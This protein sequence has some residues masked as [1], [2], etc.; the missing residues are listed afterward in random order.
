VWAIQERGH[1]RHYYVAL[2]P[3]DLNHGE[4]LFIHF[5]GQRIARLLPLV[6]FVHSLTDDRRWEPPPMQATFMFDDPNLHWTSYGFIDY[7][8]MVANAIAGNYHVAVATIPLD[9]WFVHPPASAI[10]KDNSTRLSLL[11]HGNDHLSKELARPQPAAAMQRLL[12]QAVGR[13]A[14]MEARTRL[15]VARVMAPP[16]GACSETAIS[17]MAR[18]GFE[19][20]CV[21]RGSLRY[22]NGD[23]AWTRT[24]GMRPCD[25]VAGLPVIP[26]FGLSKNCRNDILIAALLRQPIVPMTHHQAVADGYELLDEMASFVNSLGDVTWR[27]MKTMSRSLYSHRQDDQALSVRMLSKRISVPVSGGTTRIRVERPWL[28]QDSAEEPLLWRTTTE[29]RRW[30]V[31]SA[32]EAIA[33][34]GGVTIEIASGPARAAGT[35]TH[36]AGP[37]RLTPVA[38]RLLTEVRD[39]ALPSIHRLAGRERSRRSA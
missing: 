8:E 39:R 26:R 9:A 32:S 27:D 15:E 1:C 2:A 36:G 16:H 23:A 13:I 31:A 37:H 18:L 21:S 3:P 29:D 6:L 28:Q 12:R 19:A 33:V 11:Y 22:H 35:E 5:S 4:A 34:R 25:I 10:F 20:V 24:I 30:K 38:R 17:E 7:G 14:R